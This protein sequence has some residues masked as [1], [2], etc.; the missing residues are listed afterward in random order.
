MKIILTN[1]LKIAVF[2]LYFLLPHIAVANCYNI[3]ATGRLANYCALDKLRNT[4]VDLRSLRF[5]DQ[6]LKFEGRVKGLG[7][8]SLKKV[9]SV[10]KNIYPILAYSDN[11][12]GGNSSEP[13]VIGNNTFLS[14]ETLY[15]KEGV[16]AG[17]GANLNG[18]YTYSKRRYV[19]YGI[20]SS[21]T[22]SPKYGIGIS[23]IN[24]SLCS[25]N[26][27]KD[28]WY[29]DACA[30]TSATNKKISDSKNNNISLM[31][32]KV[33][34]GVENVYN[35]AIFGMN[36][37]LAEKYTQKQLL[38]G[39]NNVYS[40]SLYSSVNLTLGEEVENQLTMQHAIRAK[41]TTKFANKPLKLSLNYSHLSGGVLLGVEYNRRD[42]EISASY[43]VRG[44][45]T[46]NLG[47]KNS[48]SNINYYSSSTPIFGIYFKP[49]T[50]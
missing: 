15:R 1:I 25:I 20:S 46:V 41:I 7:F 16:V 4:K 37:Y 29:I 48:K 12:N 10:S 35:E 21:H 44:N 18:R 9:S 23:S 2:G 49:F 13:L 45:L 14:D 24:A 22:R 31:G 28:W 33:Y 11:I 36:L 26:H 50:F 38:V 3:G 27:I 40:N 34:S 17:M 19:S 30:Y 47:Y 42:Y 8:P 32:S 5:I 6:K 39:Y 43:P